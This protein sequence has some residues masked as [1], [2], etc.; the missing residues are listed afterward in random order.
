MH[1]ITAAAVAETSHLILLLVGEGPNIRVLNHSNSALL[2]TYRIFH[3]QAIHGIR[4]Q[5]VSS[6][7][8]DSQPQ[9]TCLIWGGRIIRQVALKVKQ[10]YDDIEVE[11]ISLTSEIHV[12][13]WILDSIFPSLRQSSSEVDLPLIEAVI[14]TS[15]DAV[16][17]LCSE[18][19]LNPT[20]L[21]ERSVLPCSVGPSSV[22]YSGHMTWQNP[23]TLYVA[24]GSVFGEV[25]LWTCQVSHVASK[26]ANPALGSVLASFT[27]HEGSIFGV[28]ISGYAEVSRTDLPHRV[29]A[30][31]SDDRTI[32]IWDISDYLNAEAIE[33]LIKVSAV[34]ADTGFGFQ[35][36]SAGRDNNNL[37][38]TA[39]GHT[40]RIWN[41]L[42][43]SSSPGV[44]QFLSVG[45]D[46]TI[47]SWR[48]ES[49]SQL[50]GVATKGPRGYRLLL[51]QTYGYHNGKNIWA[52]SVHVKSDDSCL[53]VTGGADGRL[54]TCS[55]AAP[56]SSPH[57][58]YSAELPLKFG[59]STKHVAQPRENSVDSQ[60]SVATIFTGL[61]GNWTLCRVLKSAIPSY[62]SGTFRGKA[63]L[64]T[65]PPTDSDYEAELL[66][67]EEGELLTDKGFQLKGSRRYVYRYQAKS[68]S[69][70]A[71][72]VKNDDDA[73]VDYLFHQLQYQ[74]SNGEEYQ[75][76]ESNMHV[77]SSAR[78]YHLCIE[79]QYVAFYTF[80]HRAST[81]TK[82]TLKYNVKGPKKDYTTDATFTRI[83]DSSSR[84]V[85]RSRTF[86]E[87]EEVK[88]DTPL[89]ACTDSFKDYRW[90]D[91]SVFLATTREGRV[92]RG[93]VEA[94]DVSW[95]VVD[96][97]PELVSWSII[98]PGQGDTVILSGNT[99]HIYYYSKSARTIRTLAKLPRKLSFQHAQ[100]MGGSSR[101]NPRFGIVAFCLGSPFA[102]L[103]LFNAGKDPFDERKSVEISIELELPPNF[104]T[105]SARFVELSNLLVLGSRSGAICFY[106][107]TLFTT[108]ANMICCGCIRHVHGDDAVTSIHV[109][110]TRENKSHETH[111]LTTGRD[112]RYAI[113]CVRRRGNHGALEI[114]METVHES[115]P[116]LGP[117][118]EGACVDRQTGDLQIWGFRS[119]DFVV[120]NESTQQEIMRVE[121]GGCHRSWS[122]SPDHNG[123]GGGSF[124][125]T[126]VSTCHIF[127]QKEATHKVI[128]AGG[129]GREIKAIAL[130]PGANSLSKNFNGLIATGAEDTVIRIF[131][132]CEGD[133]KIR[134]GFK[135]RATLTK[136]ITGIQQL[137]W[138]EDG[139]FLFSAGGCEEFYVWKVRS[140]PCLG[141]GVVC[142]YK[143]SKVTEDG[144]LRIMDF[145]VVIVGSHTPD[146]GTTFLISMVYSDSS[147]RV[148][149]YLLLI[150]I[151]E[152]TDYHRYGDTFR[153]RLRQ[154]PDCFL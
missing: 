18:A 92:L 11:C 48:L 59:L 110:E 64:T 9:L 120:W 51:D 105:T 122:Y 151:M 66:Y 95:T 144:D 140:V 141:V 153:L 121:C 131:S 20:V 36:E 55:I 73:T 89:Q 76:D 41:L 126:K 24:S 79:D 149:S 106:N 63:S 85:C 16:L 34:S 148:S 96:H 118:I 104:I 46:A 39:R 145:H 129:H 26:S 3:S 35:A 74:G 5:N 71:W 53:L 65:R 127:V 56:Q 150:I 136:H 25:I 29:L 88:V 75:S 61:K 135:C 91:K 4:L 116:P 32:K 107:G 81:M 97:I 112:G 52:A 6:T 90:I 69:I 57:D 83:E 49:L 72:F 99:G 12:E 146:T 2:C 115:H 147:A 86:E 44:W 102:S 1:P 23:E 77:P 113:H 132:G 17:L 50:E 30:S 82:W 78:G 42:Y 28:R 27:G 139:H 111:L 143:F 45:E 62:P 43:I 93:I 37:L 125:W 133:S 22:L 15:S 21:D 38:A 33:D 154:K 80:E 47:R 54:V 138:S 124:V 19:N 119:K 100:M 68:N 117:N 87:T 98:G 7:S 128:Q 10:R 58:T 40:S 130:Q 152:H 137:C 101:N 14:L 70:S 142:E 8:E 60:L 108:S 123:Q 114:H 13:D 109:I 94:I 103:L 84:D 31:C 67:F 134:R